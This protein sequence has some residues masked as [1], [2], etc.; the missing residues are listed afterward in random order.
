[1]SPSQK[2]G[3]KM[4]K[5]VGLIIILVLSV[6]A[7]MISLAADN[8][9][10]IGENSSGTTIDTNNGTV[11]NNSEK[12]KIS[13][14]DG[15]VVTNNGTIDRN[16]GTVE[17]N[18][19]TVTNAGGTVTNNNGIVKDT[20]GS[21]Y[22]GILVWGTNGVADSTATKAYLSELKGSVIDLVLF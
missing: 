9:G 12:G 17:Y 21:E 11:E 6:S 22:D 10:K 1:M 13:T 15:Y 20:F 16:T 4:K 3:E 8:G 19:G 18:Y 2:K 5:I 7:G 14:N